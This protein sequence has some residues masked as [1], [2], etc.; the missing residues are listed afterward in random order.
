MSHAIV[1]MGAESAYVFDIPYKQRYLACSLLPSICFI[2][3]FWFL[4]DLVLG[5]KGHSHGCPVL[6]VT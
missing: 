3:S 5:M 1:T 4:G 2:L 6:V